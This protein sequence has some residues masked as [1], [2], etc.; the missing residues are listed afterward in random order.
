MD[1]ALQGNLM[2]NSHIPLIYVQLYMKGNLCL[3]ENGGMVVL[4]SYADSHTSR[5]HISPL[6][7]ARA[8]A[9]ESRATRYSRR[10]RA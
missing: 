4:I 9:E 2:T 7:A 5:F 10:E 8:R 1:S 6:E 3:I